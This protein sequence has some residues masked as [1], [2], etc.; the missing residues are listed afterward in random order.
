MGSDISLDE[1]DV[2]IFNPRY[3]VATLTWVMVIPLPGG[4]Q[5][6]R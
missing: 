2:S 4:Y 3:D 5:C 1:Q 6:S